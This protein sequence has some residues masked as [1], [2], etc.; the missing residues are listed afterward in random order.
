MQDIL[1]SLH[2]QIFGF[3]RGEYGPG[4]GGTQIVNPFTRLYWLSQGEG[5]VHL[6]DGPQV[7][8]QPGRLFLFPAHRLA[9]YSCSQTMLL[10][11]VHLTAEVLGGAMDLSALAELPHV[12]SPEEPALVSTLFARFMAVP[13][14]EG[15]SH[16]LERDGILRQLL[17]PFVAAAEHGGLL[18][19]R[20]QEIGRFQG[21]IQH[22]DDH[23]DKP[24]TLAGLA[25]IAHLHPTYFSNLFAQRFGMPPLQYLNRRRIEH[26]QRRLWDDKV[27]VAEVAAAL[28]FADQ[29][30]F[31]RMFKRFTGL[32]PLPYRRQRL[33]RLNG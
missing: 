27:T 2:V 11:W 17:A 13:E 10:N 26:A 19:R 4:W 22:M 7:R 5:L 12:V 16:D 28:G 8:L 6:H 21:V 18:S 20:L 31:S 14:T 9:D 15:F 24:Q 29:F 25:A 23:L 30:H 1:S 3:R 32:S 33:L